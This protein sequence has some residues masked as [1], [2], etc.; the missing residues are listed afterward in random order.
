M[1]NL[2]L[3]KK[4]YIYIYIYVRIHLGSSTMLRFV[5]LACR[6]LGFVP[7]GVLAPA[8]S[9]FRENQCQSTVCRSVMEVQILQPKVTVQEWQRALMKMKCFRTLHSV[10]SKSP[11]RSPVPHSSQYCRKPFPSQLHNPLPRLS[12]LPSNLCLTSTWDRSRNW[13]TS[14]CPPKDSVLTIEDRLTKLET[15][16]PGSSGEHG[17][18]LTERPKKLEAISSAAS[19]PRSLDGHPTPGTWGPSSLFSPA[20]HGSPMAPAPVTA[21]LSSIFG[22]APTFPYPAQSGGPETSE[23]FNRSSDHTIFKIRTKY[24]SSRAEATHHNQK[25]SMTWQSLLIL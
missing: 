2:T 25:C 20:R 11:N 22:D 1:H 8:N 13:L 17:Q 19:P 15:S 24:A 14:K 4:K 18:A 9:S 12:S 6:I 23:A 3:R 7:L 21:H 16:P 10:M 5:S